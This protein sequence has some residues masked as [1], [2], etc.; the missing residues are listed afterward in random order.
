MIHS[1]FVSGDS[2][3]SIRQIAQGGGGLAQLKLR[4]LAKVEG[5][6]VFGMAA[7]NLIRLPKLLSTRGE[8]CPEGGR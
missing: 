5:V 7:Y 3:G 1:E 2:R 8:V 6:F 4:G